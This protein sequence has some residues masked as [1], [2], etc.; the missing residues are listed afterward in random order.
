MGLANCWAIKQCGRE[1]GGAKVPEL[2]ECLVSS[3]D[4]GHSCWAIAGT[5]CA[6]EVQ[7]SAAQKERNCMLCDVYKKYQ[8]STGT[9]RDQVVAQYP[10]EQARYHELMHSRLHHSIN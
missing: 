1:S 7:G 4:M 8:R 3:D 6:G 5:L 2:G 9:D 10:E